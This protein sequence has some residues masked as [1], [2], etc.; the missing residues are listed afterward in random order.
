MKAALY[1]GRRDIRIEEFP[2]P[3]PRFKEVKIAIKWAGIC[4]SDM[5]EYADGPTPSIPV[6]KPHPL[7]GNTV[8]LVFGHEMAGEVVEIGEGVTKLAVGDRVV[9]EPLVVCGE[10]KACL[11]GWYNVCE[12]MGVHGQCGS[13]GGFAEFTTFPER[14]VHKVPDNVDYETASLFE[15]LS[16]AVH[17]AVVGGLEIGMNAVVF[18][19]GPVG[20][21]QIKVLKAAGA[22]QVICVQRKS[23]RQ[24]LAKLAGADLVLDPAECD[25]VAEIRKIT[26][27]GADISF[28]LTGAPPCWDWSIKCLRGKGTLVA[29]GIFMEEVTFNPSYIADHEIKIQGTICYA[30]NYPAA[31]QLVADGRVKLDNIITKRI[32]LDDLVSEGFEVLMGPEKK[33]QSKIIVTPDRSLL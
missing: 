11:A 20:L 5:H 6:S 14:F 12:K 3:E 22:K 31:I 8:P 7:T 18:G 15:P 29:L 13:G 25:P 28:E 9:V 17:A 27:G 23:L 1:Y 4:G 19:A 32:H 24:E 16:V 26:D 33:K 30:R 10:C 2:E 21:M